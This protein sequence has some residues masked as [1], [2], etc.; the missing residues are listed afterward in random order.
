M[1]AAHEG[2]EG[3][4]RDYYNPPKCRACG[5]TICPNVWAC[6]N[7]KCVKN[8]PKPKA[9]SSAEVGPLQAPQKTP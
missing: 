2:G 4:M 9:K 1:A 7:P 5:V 3:R 6:C 8:A